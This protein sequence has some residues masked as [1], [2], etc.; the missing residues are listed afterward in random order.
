MPTSLKKTLEK[1]ETDLLT[2]VRDWLRAAD[3]E[4][5]R[6]LLTVLVE[7]EEVEVE[8][9]EGNVVAGAFN[10]LQEFA[11]TWAQ[12]N[13]LL[14]QVEAA[15]PEEGDEE[16][17]DD[18]EETSEAEKSGAE[19]AK[20]AAPQKVSGRKTPKHRHCC[21]IGKHE[22]EAAERKGSHAPPASV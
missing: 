15:D 14:V 19:T 5:M 18:A 22:A 7:L 16:D 4:K 21:E 2:E 13:N 11:V 20:S 10:A 12:L 1:A 3:D 9:E 6:E 17:E 8:D